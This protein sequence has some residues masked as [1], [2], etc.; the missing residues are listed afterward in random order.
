MNLFNSLIENGS[1]AAWALGELDNVVPMAIFPPIEH[2]NKAIIKAGKALAG[3]LPYDPS[4]W[5]EYVKLFRIAHEWRSSHVPPLRR[6]M[7]E[8]QSNV[9]KAKVQGVSAARMKRMWSIRQKLGRSTTNLV[10]MQDIGGCRVIVPSMIDLEKMVAHY[11]DGGTRHH[12]RQN[13]SYIDD[14]KPDGYR[15][16]HFVLAYSPPSE[17]TAACE[18]RRIEVQVRTQLQHSWGT[19]VEAVGLYRK[20]NLKAGDGDADW[21]RLFAL[22]SADFAEA[23]HSAPIPHMTT[24]AKRRTELARLDKK[25]HAANTLRH[26]NEAFKIA[27]RWETEAKFF[28]IRY[29]R[30]AQKVEVL[31][32]S[33]MNAGNEQYSTWEQANGDSNAVLVEV[34]RVED[35]RIA[36][37]NYFGDVALF[38]KNLERMIRSDSVIMENEAVSANSGIDLSFVS[39]DPNWWRRRR[40]S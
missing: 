9:R 1:H 20:E 21:L 14:P 8:L 27:E 33:S 24:K 10:Q 38:T 5:D 18:G 35:L 32:Y 16:H 36:Y 22:V 28:L 23:E 34:S 30:A 26:L 39:D 19:A 12:L 6:I 11:R 2:S 3:R 25:L 13:T 15:S 37:P 17:D 7:Q 31:P 29:D 40:K 4:K